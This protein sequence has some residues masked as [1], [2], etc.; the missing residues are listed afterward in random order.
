MS[1][2]IFSALSHRAAILH[3]ISTRPSLRPGIA[4]ALYTI[5]QPSVLLNEPEMETVI[6]HLFSARLVCLHRLIAR[7]PP[8]VQ[9]P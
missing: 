4:C 3:I 9:K 5:T 6:V 2:L 8:S 1:I 7:H